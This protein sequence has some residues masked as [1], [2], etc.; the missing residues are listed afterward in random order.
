MLRRVPP[1]SR[2]PFDERTNV[3][4]PLLVIGAAALIGAALGTALGRDANQGTGVGAQEVSVLGVSIERSEH[5]EDDSM[6]GVDVGREAWSDSVVRIRSDRC[7]AR[8]TVATG[9]VIDG[10]VLTNRHVVEG[11]ATIEVETLD[12]RRFDAV[13]MR[14][15]TWI[16]LAAF[17]VAELDGGL[18]LAL[19][20]SAQRQVQHPEGPT[21]TMPG[22]PE[23]GALVVE[24]VAA[25]ATRRGVAFPD[26]PEAV[27]LSDRV[28]PG[29]SGSPV[30]DSD[31]KVAGILY[32]SAHDSGAGLMI[33]AATITQ[34]WPQMRRVGFSSCS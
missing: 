9:V 15:S 31:N 25:V 16:D 12:G 32:A 18:E 11:A 6:I 13:S 21:W 1:S 33:D 2:P 3:A 26:P 30:I 22:F 19:A 10:V 8:N 4:K 7:D 23:G 17:S 14:Q 27:E 29:Q 34:A 20:Q 5:G 24:S 28:V